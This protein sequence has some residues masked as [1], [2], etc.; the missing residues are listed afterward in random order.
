MT[1]NEPSCTR[2][3]IPGMAYRCDECGDEFCSEHLFHV[4]GAKGQFCDACSP[5]S[6]SGSA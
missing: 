3:F 6:E 1:C 4:I 5:T 2:M